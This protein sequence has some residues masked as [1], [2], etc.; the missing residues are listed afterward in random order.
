[1]AVKIL[2]KDKVVRQLYQKLHKIYAEQKKK[3]KIEWAGAFDKGKRDSTRNSSRAKGSLHPNFTLVLTPFLSS[4]PPPFKTILWGG[5]WWGR[6]RHALFPTTRRSV[7]TLM[8]ESCQTVVQAPVMARNEATKDR[9]IYDTTGEPKV[10]PVE[11][12]EP[13]GD[14]VALKDVPSSDD[15]S[16][17]FV[18]ASLLV[19][20]AALGMAV[21][22]QR[23]NK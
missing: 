19:A 22:L 15:G 6:L 16:N 3:E 18:M 10:A 13:S 20:T 2:P 7:R 14:E 9:D 23:R 8:S 11:D 12:I 1:M 17:G 4:Y 21:L 5:W